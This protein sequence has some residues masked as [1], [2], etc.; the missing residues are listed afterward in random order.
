V[1]VTTA[2]PLAQALVQPRGNGR[3]E[4]PCGGSCGFERGAHVVTIGGDV[5]ACDCPAYVI[6]HRTCRHIAAVR[7]HLVL[8]PV[9]AT[10]APEAGPGLERDIPLPD[11]QADGS[12]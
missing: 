5:V 9:E 11:D 2:T 12:A 6:A 8:A 1:A 10:I 3:Y 7:D 4:V